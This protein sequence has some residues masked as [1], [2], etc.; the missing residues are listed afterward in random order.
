MNNFIKKI[1]KILK[2]NYPLDILFE[3]IHYLSHFWIRSNDWNKFLPF[4]IDIDG[5]ILN[6]QYKNYKI[7]KVLTLEKVRISKASPSAYALSQAQGARLTNKIL[8]WETY[9]LLYISL[10]NNSY[11]PCIDI[12]KFM[13][14]L[15]TYNYLEFLNIK[16]MIIQKNED[17]ID[18]KIDY[19]N[20]IN[21]NL[22]WNVNSIEQ[23]IN[24]DNH[25]YLDSFSVNDNYKKLK[26]NIDRLIE[27]RDKYK[28]I[29]F[30]LD[31]NGGGDIV[32]AHIILRCLLGILNPSDLRPS[33]S[34]QRSKDSLN[35]FEGMSSPKDLRQSASGMSNPSR[36]KSVEREKWMK[37]IAKII[38]DG[39]ILSFE[40]WDCWAEENKDSPNCD[41]VKK[42]NLNVLSKYNTKYNGKIYLHMNKQNGSAVW[43]FITYL[44]YSF[45]TKIHRFSKKC[46]GRTIKYGKIESDQLIL[47]GHSGTTS[48]DGNSITI[49]YDNH[50][51]I[52]CPT[53][54]FIS[55][56]IKKYDWNRFWTEM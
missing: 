26:I 31:N 7:I 39:Y 16:R 11:L 52:E 38:K 6:G 5:L 48:G 14:L 13:Y 17:I 49:K 35:L 21:Y 2:K 51:N 36:T 28:E 1:N 25:F 37:K 8:D 44:I 20:K 41:V 9:K 53:Q 42:L 4:N 47:L 30:H 15:H 43:F 3:D 45:S 50:I 18:Y 32:P 55:C 10:L 22:T 33:A 12:N 46:Y 54:Q 40:E 24:K 27:N 34:G 56:S 19:K 23:H 29:H